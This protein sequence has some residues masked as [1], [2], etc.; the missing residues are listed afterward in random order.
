MKMMKKCFLQGAFQ[1][2][3][4]NSQKEQR[5]KAFVR[6]QL[7]QIIFQAEFAPVQQYPAPVN[8]MHVGYNHTDYQP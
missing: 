1:K 6:I 2:D 3:L 5:A 4:K 8:P 7:E